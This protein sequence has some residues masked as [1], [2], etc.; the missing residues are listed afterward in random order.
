MRA[1]RQVL[2]AASALSGTSE[3]AALSSSHFISPKANSFIGRNP[4]DEIVNPNLR[5]PWTQQRLASVIWNTNTP[6][7]YYFQNM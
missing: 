2:D 5:T 3:G 7:A 4:D 1:R 6:E